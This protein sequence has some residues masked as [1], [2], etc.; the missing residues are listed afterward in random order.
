M[1]MT[2]S[3]VY[4]NQ[5]GRS[6]VHPHHP[7]TEPLHVLGVSP[8]AS[9]SEIKSAYRKLALSCHPDKV[10]GT[11]EETLEA[12]DKF[13]Q[14]SAAY[15]L[16]TQVCN[17]ERC[18]GT[19][20]PVFFG[21]PTL[22]P[23]ET[24]TDPYALFR[25][26]FGTES[27][28]LPPNN[29]IIIGDSSMLFNAWT[30]P[31]SVTPEI[32][33]YLTN[34]PYERPNEA[35]SEPMITNVAEERQMEDSH[36][37]MALPKWQQVK[38]SWGSRVEPMKMNDANKRHFDVTALEMPFQKRRRT[39]PSWDQNAVFHKRDINQIYPGDAMEYDSPASK[40]LRMVCA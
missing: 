18:P 3:P 32:A 34:E 22:S 16:L 27:S 33:G 26:T 31:Q 2:N 30:T 21:T 19:P 17:G 13:A 7:G 15:E 4:N 25:T 5:P 35:T 39:L 36:L 9:F 11:M 24:F 38:P 40:R 28:S 10:Q 1:I 37:E 29:S 20:Y 6:I 14:I 8:N 12:Q 23:N